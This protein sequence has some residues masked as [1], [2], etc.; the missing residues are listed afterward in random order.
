VSPDGKRVATTLREG[1]NQDIWTYDIERDSMTR[2]TFG[3]QTFVSAIWSP[4]GRYI[5]AGSIGNGLFWVRADGGGQPQQLVANRRISFPHSITSDGQRLVYYEIGG[6][7]QIWTVPLELS[8][9][10][11]AG[12]PERFLTTESADAA[13]AFSPDGR[14]L[15]YESNESG[16]QEI[17][18]RPFPVSASGGGKWQISNNGGAWP[19]WSAKR[20]EILYRSGNQVLAVGYMATGDSFSPEKPRVLATTPGAAPGFDIAPDGRLLMMM[21]TIVDGSKT[22]HTLMFVQNFYDELRRRVPVGK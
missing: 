5:I 14:W 9:G 11:K 22:D 2:L 19:I 13:A 4:D 21:P 12:T 6:F 16:R 3:T 18:V 20:H 1:T 17:Y 15:A 10:I 8:D 7:P